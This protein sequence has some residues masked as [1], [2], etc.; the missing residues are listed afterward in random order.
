MRSD[1]PDTSSDDGV[2]V[3]GRVS[4]E[5]YLIRATQNS[6]RLLGANIILLLL[7]SIHKGSVYGVFQ[8]T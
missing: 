8:T 1:F 7:I 3:S 5:A 6:R 4:L 2:H